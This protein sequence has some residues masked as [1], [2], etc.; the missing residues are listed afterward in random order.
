MLRLRYHAT[1]LTAAFLA[2]ALLVVAAPLA[3]ARDHDDRR[4]D[5]MRRAVEAGEIRSLADIIAGVRGQL[6]GEIAGVEIEREDGHWIYEF[7]VIDGKGR[8]FE[9]YIDA[10]SGTIERIKE[11]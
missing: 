1:V 5:D 11:K 2:A 7:R 4:R 10:R 8:L 6:P 9:V 3:R